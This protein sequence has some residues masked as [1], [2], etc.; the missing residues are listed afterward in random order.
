MLIKGEY[1][2]MELLIKDRATGKTTG[3]IYTSEATGYPI[4]VKQRNQV[5]YVKEKACEMG[6]IIPEPICVLD[7]IG[8]CALMRG[9]R[10]PTHV[11]VDEI[12]PIISEALK[13]YLG[14][15]VVCATMTDPRRELKKGTKCS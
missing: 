9:V 3:L 5:N 15:E 13:N 4:V 7:M 14:S 2:S 12:Y 10:K 8:D 1:V 6:C 11:L